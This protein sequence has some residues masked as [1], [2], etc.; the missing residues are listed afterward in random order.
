MLLDFGND[1]QA[2]TIELA[3]EVGRKIITLAKSEDNVST[4][5]SYQKDVRAVGQLERGKVDSK[6][7]V[8]KDSPN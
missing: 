7:E 6:R 1:E 3:Q 2:E 5:T 4:E 8:N